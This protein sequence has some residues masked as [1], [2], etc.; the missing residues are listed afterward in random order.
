MAPGDP[1]R[2]TAALRQREGIEL[3]STLDELNKLAGELG[4]AKL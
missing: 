2:R 1:E 4:V 3:G